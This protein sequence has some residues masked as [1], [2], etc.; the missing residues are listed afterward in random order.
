MTSYGDDAYAFCSV[1]GYETFFFNEHGVGLQSYATER[2]PLISYPSQ[3]SCYPQDSY[4][5]S[6]PEFSAYVQAAEAAIFAGCYPE[7]IK[8]GSSGS[9]FVR[10]TSGV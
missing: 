8:K 4:V 2:T 10:D 5:V 1:F 6:D 3:V 9:Y 7:R